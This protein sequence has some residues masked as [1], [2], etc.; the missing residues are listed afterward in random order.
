MSST[1]RKLSPDHGKREPSQAKR[2]S[3]NSEPSQGDTGKKPKA[4]KKEASV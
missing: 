4:G 1:L 2:D 3:A